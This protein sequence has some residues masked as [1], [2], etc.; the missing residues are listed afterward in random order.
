MCDARYSARMGTGIEVWSEFNVAM[1]GGLAALV[2]LLIVAMSVNV[3][4]ILGAP[5]LPARAAAAIATLTL[6]LVVCALGLVPIQPLWLYGIETAVGA[7]IAAVFAFHA[8][9]SVYRNTHAPQG[10]RLPKSAA[11]IAPVVAYAAG[12]VLMIG[13]SDAGLAWLAAGA[14]LAVISGVT[15]AWVV[16]IEILR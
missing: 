13:G 8:V 14:I 7:L 3:T 10:T 2:G 5:H 16:L 11:I 1:L 12:A 15:F 4:A 6:A 9:R